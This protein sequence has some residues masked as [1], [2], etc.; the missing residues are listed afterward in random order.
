MIDLLLEIKIKTG[1]LENPP[2]ETSD[3]PK[4]RGRKKQIAAKNL[5]DRLSEYHG[6]SSAEGIWHVAEQ[7]GCRF[8]LL[9][10]PYASPSA[11]S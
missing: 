8:V 1:L 10:L 3:R 9:N 7:A 5:L 6:E 2:P 11:A 4:N